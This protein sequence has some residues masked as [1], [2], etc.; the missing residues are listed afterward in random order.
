MDAKSNWGG[1]RE[2][3]DGRAVADAHPHLIS[4]RVECSPKGVPAEFQPES[5]PNW[6]EPPPQQILGIDGTPVCGEYEVSKPAVLYRLRPA[7]ASFTTSW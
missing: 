2:G 6:L 7:A 3:H 4:Q 1:R 5:F